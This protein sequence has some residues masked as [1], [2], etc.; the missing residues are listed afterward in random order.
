M[1]CVV[2][3]EGGG[4]GC[5]GVKSRLHSELCVQGQA[6][7]KNPLSPQ[8]LEFEIVGKKNVRREKNDKSAKWRIKIYCTDLLLLNSVI[9]Y[10][11]VKLSSSRSAAAATSELLHRRNSKNV[12]L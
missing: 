7:K 2:W 3:R 10:K 1:F 6:F 9:A 4:R 8:A 5:G 11:P 12:N